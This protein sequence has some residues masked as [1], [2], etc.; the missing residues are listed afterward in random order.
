MKDAEGMD[1]FFAD[2]GILSRIL[3]GYEPR[4]EQVKMSE[5][6]AD[7][8]KDGQHLIVEAGTG[9]GKSLAYL[10]P[11]IEWALD[12]DDSED[13]G[14]RRAVVSTYTKALQRQLIEK[15]LP[16]LK[17]NI[18]KDLRFALCIGSEN[19]LCL[20]RFEQTKTHG[21]F[22]SDET[23]AI[24][25]LLKWVKKTSTG[26]RAE[27]DI[28]QQLWQ[29]VCRESDLCYG[30]DC[31]KIDLCFYQK[32]KLI[33]RR[34]H[35][36]IT[37]HH[38]F[39]ANVVSGW[40]VIPSF[41]SIIFDEAHELE[42]VAADYLCVEISNFKLRHLLDSILSPH[43]KG[44][45]SRLKWL[46]QASFSKVSAIVNTVRIHGEVFFGELSEKLKDSTTLR[47]HEKGFIKDDLSESLMNLTDAL[48]MLQESSD[49]EDEEKEIAALS[50]RSEAVALSLRSILQ[51]E[52]EG[53]VYWAERDGRSIRLVAT[54]I[55]IASILKKQVFD[56]VSPAIL[57][58]ATLT[59]NGN[60]DYVKERLGL[61][62]AKALL[63]HSPFDYNKQALLYV[64]DDLR[65]PGSEGFEEDLI[66]HIKEILEVTMGRTLVL[67]TSY[68]LLNKAYDAIGIPELKILRQ[69]NTDSYRLVQ[70]FRKGNHSV[71][72]GTYTFWQGIDIP[73]DDLQ[74]VIITKLP[75][76][77]PDEPVT[78]ARMEALQREGKDPF[79]HYQIPQAVILF[80]QGFGRLIRTKTDRGVVTILDSRVRT[81]GYGVQFLKSLPEC[82]A[83]SSIDDIKGF[84]A[85][86]RTD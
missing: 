14:H 68:S 11:V 21:L 60:F 20:R 4:I 43:G 16:F 49:D 38:L 19:Y 12:R 34:A 50:L 73:G 75:F 72:F 58:S 70:E 65:R 63:L 30:K 77:V 3:K 74:C 62:D 85:D 46:T 47:I 51:Q 81:K 86:S 55:D 7:A 45:L 18:F 79:L 31:K 6:I 57:T 84:L 54:P 5:A 80:K 83:T 66:T 61:S 25:G 36:L 52:F 17:D 26:I 44:L 37:N 67:F 10:I 69:G 13:S 15:E 22:D 28:P 29:K 24:N 9:V 39:F 48:K 35:I 64:P 23:E 56:I 8:L 1:R 33:E 2:A 40:N 41:N 27:I 42:D 59:T 53:H 76:A 71:L 32:A 78:E 82:K